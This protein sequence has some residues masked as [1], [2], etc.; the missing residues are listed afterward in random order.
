MREANIGADELSDFRSE[1][2][3]DVSPTT[4]VLRSEDFG[5]FFVHFEILGEDG[6]AR[7]DPSPAPLPPLSDGAAGEISD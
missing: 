4:S 6:F 7:E 3:E 5:F 1:L 2:E